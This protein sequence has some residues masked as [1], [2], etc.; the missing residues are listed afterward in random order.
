MSGHLLEEGTSTFPS[1]LSPFYTIKSHGQRTAHTKTA[2]FT[3]KSAWFKNGH[4]RV[5]VDGE[6]V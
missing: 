1:S 5:T 3:E 4:C 6:W 2:T